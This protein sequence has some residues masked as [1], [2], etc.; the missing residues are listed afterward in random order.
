M[1]RGGVEL[2]GE[3]GKGRSALSFGGKAVPR[4]P[5]SFLVS[6]PL[7]DQFSESPFECAR[8]ARTFLIAL[9]HGSLRGRPE[10]FI[11]ERLG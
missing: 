4:P 6:P 5:E 7:P 11:G 9:H 1:P 10:G 2:P 3:P 8:L